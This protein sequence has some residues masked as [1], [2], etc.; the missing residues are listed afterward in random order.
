MTQSEFEALLQDTSKKIVGDIVWAEDEDRS[1]SVQFRGDLISDS[2]YPLLVKGSYNEAARTLTFVLI[3]RAIG[4]IYRLDMG[5]DHHNPSCSRVGDV[6][7]HR[8]TEQFWDKEAYAPKDI[9][10]PVTSP[11]EVWKQF[12]QEASIV[13]SGIMHAPP[14]QQSDLF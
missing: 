10:A 8:W 4:C 1:P 5:K 12:C 6:H 11:V 3:H 9:T 7:K 13:H 14:A 2:G